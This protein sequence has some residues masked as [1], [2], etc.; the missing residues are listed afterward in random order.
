M[1][2]IIIILFSLFYSLNIVGQT[3]I[4]SSTAK[5]SEDPYGIFS[6]FSGNPGK[7]ALYSLVIPGAGQ[8]YNKRYWKIPIVLAAEGAAIYFLVERINTY[9]TW[10]NTWK[11]LASGIEPVDGYTISQIQT[12]KDIRDSARSNKDN[13]WLILLGV[14]LIVTADAFIDRH[15]IEFDV[16]DDLSFKLNTDYLGVGI[17]YQF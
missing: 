13:Q 17:V 7:A 9:K 15:L 3:K 1:N 11:Q 8:Y 12:V 2:R 6:M 16:S 4:D 5:Q 10:D 14:H